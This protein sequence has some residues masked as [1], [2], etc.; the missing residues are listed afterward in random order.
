M[1]VKQDIIENGSQLLGK[2]GQNFERVEVVKQLI[3]PSFIQV[4]ERNKD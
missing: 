2:K 3:N 1:I 4:I